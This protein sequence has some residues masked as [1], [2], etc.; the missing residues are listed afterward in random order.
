MFRASSE[1]HVDIK[2]ERICF[3]FLGKSGIN[4]EI[5]L[6]EKSLSAIVKQCQDLPGQELFQYRDE[7]GKLRDVGSVDVN[8]YLREIS[9]GDFTAKDFRTWAGTSLAA[10]A[11]QEFEEFTSTTS[12]REN[13]SK[14]IEQVA[15]RLGNTKAI[16]RKCY[17]HPAVIDAY[18][19]R[20]L[21]ISLKKSGKNSPR[22]SKNEQGVLALIQAHVREKG[23]GK[24]MLSS[25]KSRRTAKPH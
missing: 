7:F 4:H 14:A 24:R 13:L 17:I 10:E 19:N 8:A 5:D 15:E 9:G 11:L 21:L 2:G 18:L 12:A 20:S 23:G 1:R 16:C 6:E 22:I 3:E 25:D